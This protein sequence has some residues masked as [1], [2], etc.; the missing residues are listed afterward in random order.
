MPLRFTIQI[1][2]LRAPCA[3]EIAAR[4]LPAPPVSPRL[5]RALLLNLRPGTA[6]R[7]PCPPLPKQVHQTARVP[8]ALL[9]AHHC[10]PLHSSR[11]RQR[12]TPP[13][14]LPLQRPPTAAARFR[15]SLAT[16]L[17]APSTRPR[18]RYHRPL[19]DR[20][21]L[22]APL[23]TSLNSTSRLLRLLP[24]HQLRVACLLCP[25][26]RS[27]RATHPSTNTEHPPARPD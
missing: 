18:R 23:V 10:C 14:P 20:A 19:A 16:A 9:L 26:S 11:L 7:V 21:A 22:P 27:P 25:R 2:P 5:S 1:I 15:P 8:D 24:T 13:L 6:R 12:P 17:P 3:S 4:S